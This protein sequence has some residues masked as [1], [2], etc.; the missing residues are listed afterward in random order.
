MKDFLIFI[1]GIV[2]GGLSLYAWQGYYHGQRVSPDA[3][4]SPVWLKDA[5]ERQA[6]TVTYGKPL[7]V[8][9]ID[10]GQAFSLTLNRL[11]G[12][13]VRYTWRSITDGTSKGDGELF[14]KYEEVTKSPTGTHV[15][16]V[17]GSLE[18]HLESFALE[19]S[20][21]SESSGFIYYDP[22]KFALAH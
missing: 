22:R 12:G 19:W 6:F 11:P 21:G 15:K 5:L 17:G 10:S 9:I 7:R 14:E 2:F 4:T 13:K 1:A 3:P 8:D 20:W 18:I 16:D